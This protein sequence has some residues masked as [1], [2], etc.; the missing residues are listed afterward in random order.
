MVKM[1]VKKEIRCHGELVERSSYWSFCGSLDTQFKVILTNNLISWMYRHWKPSPVEEWLKATWLLFIGQARKCSLTNPMEGK[2]IFGISSDTLINI[3]F[4][5]NGASFFSL[6][7]L[8]N[9]FLE[10]ARK[11]TLNLT[12]IFHVAVRL[13]IKRKL[14][15]MKVLLFSGINFCVYTYFQ[16]FC[17][18]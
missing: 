18:I 6:E 16:M 5:L 7:I 3:E 9:Y 2:L 1:R 8:V 10:R 12:N 13:F 11:S 17:P 14:I 4:Q 15:E